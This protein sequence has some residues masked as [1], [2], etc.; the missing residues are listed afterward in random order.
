MAEAAWLGPASDLRIRVHPVRRILRTIFYI[1]WSVFFTASAVYDLRRG[2]RLEPLV[3]LAL[4]VAPIVITLVAERKVWVAADGRDLVVKDIFSTKR[5]AAKDI[6]EF[7]VADSSKKPPCVLLVP[8]G[9]NP[10]ELDATRRL[11]WGI[12]RGRLERHLGQLQAWHR[13][14][15]I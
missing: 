13:A 1:A 11:Y 2:K 10:V 6:A 7:R 15:T 5:Y 8:H 3:F 9:G 4:F 14:A 12:G